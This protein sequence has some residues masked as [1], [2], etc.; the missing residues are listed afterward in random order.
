MNKIYQF[1]ISLNYSAPFIWRRVHVPSSFTFDNLHRVIQVLFNWDES[2]LHE[3][4]AGKAFRG[5]KISGRTPLVSYFESPKQKANYTYDFGDSW[6]HDILFEQWIETTTALTHPLCVAGA[7]NA[8]PEDCG[9]IPGYYSMLEIVQDKN[10]PDH[11]SLKEWLGEDFDPTFFDMGT[12][13]TQ[14]KK[15]RGKKRKTDS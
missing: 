13:N 2:H 6:E 8:P 4:N 1:K 14:L 11:E 12:L 15:I 5:E 9:G 7:N 3:F 10:H